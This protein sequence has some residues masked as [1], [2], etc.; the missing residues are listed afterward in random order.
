MWLP[1]RRPCHT[2]PC[3]PSTWLFCHRTHPNTVLSQMAI[4]QYQTYFYQGKIFL[5]IGRHIVRFYLFK[6]NLFSILLIIIGLFN[7]QFYWNK[8]ILF[9]TLQTIKFLK[10]VG[11]STHQHNGCFSLEPD[12][13]RLG[14]WFWMWGPL[15]YI[16]VMQCCESLLCSHFQIGNK[17]KLQNIPSIAGNL[18]P[19]QK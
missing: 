18:S 1:L 2:R 8:R 11:L 12:R 16:F 4:F 7:I 13:R 15:F 17:R 3:S 9:L 10:Q 19:T 5:P 14:M 6:K